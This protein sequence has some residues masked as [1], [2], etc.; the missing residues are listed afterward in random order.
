MNISPVA[1]TSGWG[2]FVVGD[3]E[4]GI[5]HEPEGWIGPMPI[6]MTL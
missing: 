6:S 2:L 5:Q 3:E 4:A 1:S